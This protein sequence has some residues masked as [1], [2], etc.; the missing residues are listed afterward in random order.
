MLNIE[1]HANVGRDW[2]VPF[3]I[4]AAIASSVGGIAA[5][6][7]QLE[8]TQFSRDLCAIGQRTELKGQYH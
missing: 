7:T 4:A 5:I 2:T 1:S 3:P 6:L 8:Q